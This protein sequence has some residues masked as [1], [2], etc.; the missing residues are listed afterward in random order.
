MSFKTMRLTLG[1]VLYD[2]PAEEPPTTVIGWL[3]KDLGLNIFETLQMLSG[4]SLQDKGLRVE[5]NPDGTFNIVDFTLPSS[6]GRLR[7]NIPQEDVPKHVI[8]AMAMLQ[9]AEQGSHVKG[10]GFRLSDSLY[11]VSDNWEET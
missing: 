3:Y 7:K 10:V 5:V 9:I 1:N 8:E 2:V 6:A 4:N 11:Y